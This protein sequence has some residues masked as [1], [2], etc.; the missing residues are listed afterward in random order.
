MYAFLDG[1]TGEGI[2]TCFGE[3]LLDKAIKEVRYFRHFETH[4]SKF[5]QS[6]EDL[7]TSLQKLQNDIVNSKLFMTFQQVYFHYEP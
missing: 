1:I 4:A 2:V 6:N 7:C 3:R 5:R